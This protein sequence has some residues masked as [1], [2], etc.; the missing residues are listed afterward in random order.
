MLVAVDEGKM[1][2]LSKHVARATANRGHYKF[3][4][5][6]VRIITKATGFSEAFTRATSREG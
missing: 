3:R 6:A 4:H 2:T 5:A 1:A